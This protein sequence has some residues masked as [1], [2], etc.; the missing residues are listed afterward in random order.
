MWGLDTNLKI[1]NLRSSGHF[2][3]KQPFGVRSLEVVLSCEPSEDQEKLREDMLG[4]LRK[5][6]LRV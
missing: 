6:G 4:G 1:P 3:H 5:L 2:L